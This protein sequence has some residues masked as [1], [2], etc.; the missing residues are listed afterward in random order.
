MPRIPLSPV[1]PAA[2]TI[3]TP[4]ENAHSILASRGSPNAGVPPRLRLITLQFCST[5]HSIASTKASVVADPSSLNTFPFTISIF[6]EVAN[7]LAIMVPWGTSCGL[8]SVVERSSKSYPF[9]SVMKLVSATTLPCK[10]ISKSIPESNIA[11]LTFVV[12][13]LLPGMILMIYTNPVE[14]TIIRMNM[15]AMILL[16]LFDSFFGASVGSQ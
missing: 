16:P 9:S 14:T 5:A 10:L 2:A 12:G 6:G 11:T 8:E 1:F 3:T 4:R 13:A 15:T 7:C